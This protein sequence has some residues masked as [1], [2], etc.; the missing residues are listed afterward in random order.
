MIKIHRPTQRAVIT[1][2]VYF[3]LVVN[4]VEPET[5]LLSW[6]VK[7]RQLQA[8]SFLPSGSVVAEL[9]QFL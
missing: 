8:V 1:G 6:P 4:V 9:R 2:I 7:M 3:K 5:D